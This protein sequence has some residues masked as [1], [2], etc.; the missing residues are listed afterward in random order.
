MII[1]LSGYAQSGKDTAALAITRQQSGWEIRRWAQKVKSIASLLTG[2]PEYIFENID[3][4]NSVMPDY[5]WNND[6]PI[7]YREFLQKI[8]TEAIR[9][10]I[11]EN[12]WVNALMSEYNHTCKWIITD[13]RFPNEAQ[14][15]KNAGGF[16][17]RI[18]RP[19]VKPA[20]NHPS[21]TALDN[22]NFDGYVV[23]NCNLSE[24]SNRVNEVVWQLMQNKS[25]PSE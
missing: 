15:I 19:G 4:K 25:K 24:F 17:I 1:G 13:T 5:W 20:N 18:I 16:V 21:E 9:N 10:N 11:H 22:W 7:T 3:F 23:N 14:A 6:R 2:V 8:G 12:A